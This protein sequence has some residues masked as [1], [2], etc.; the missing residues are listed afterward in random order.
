MINADM[1]N[2]DFYTYG[3]PNGYGQPTLSTEV[4]GTVKIAIFTTSQG[5]QNNI[6][7][8]G[9]SYIGLTHDAINDK[10]VIQYGDKKIKVLYVQPK[11]RFKQVFLGDM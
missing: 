1:R 11:G 5:V 8:A 2:Y 3:A 4:Q 9:A 6:N 7:Y 10:M